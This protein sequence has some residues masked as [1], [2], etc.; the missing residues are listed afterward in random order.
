MAEVRKSISWILKFTSELKSEAEKIK[1]L[2]A[3]GG[4]EILTILRGAFD[5]SIKWLLPEGNAPYTPYE[6]DGL[7][8]ALYS[9]IRRLHLFVEGY[10]PGLNQVKRERLFIELLE[11]IDPK[12]AE[13][14]VA[15]KDKK[16]PWPGLTADIVLKAFPGLF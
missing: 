4:E 2:Q 6:F 12:D 3:N 1:C 14:M 15:V 16:L 13:M 7:E 11:S 10:N 8:H 9:E 5:P